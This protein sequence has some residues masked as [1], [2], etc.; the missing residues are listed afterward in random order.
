MEKYIVKKITEANEE[1]FDEFVFE[2]IAND[3]Q[4]LVFEDS[5]I[6]GRSY[7][8]YNSFKEWYKVHE[9]LE[10]HN[11][12][13]VQ[14]NTYLVFKEKEERMRLIAAFELHTNLNENMRNIGNISIGIR[15]SERE[16]GYYAKIL[17]YAIEEAK[18]LNLEKILLTCSKDD[19]Q[20]I[21]VIKKVL[22][23][24]EIVQIGDIYECTCYPKNIKDVIRDN[25]EEIIKIGNE[26]IKK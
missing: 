25:N 24:I 9:L 18:Q 16:K 12:G 23:N 7:M 19:M 22:P 20:S 8:K 21:H 6:T 13:K 4:Q 14:V 17:R 10:K 15:P 5:L 3:E 11:E 1:E 26:K 2:H